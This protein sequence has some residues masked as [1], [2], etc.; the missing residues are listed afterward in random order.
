LYYTMLSKTKWFQLLYH[1]S[2]QIC[3]VIPC[4]FERQ[5]E[6]D[7][8]GHSRF[9]FSG[10]RNRADT[11][12]LLN[13]SWILSLCWNILRIFR[14]CRIYPASLHIK[15]TLLIN[16][17]YGKCILL[18]YAPKLWLLAMFAKLWI[19]FHDYS[20]ISYL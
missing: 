8:R 5:R 1:L 15:R 17:H 14:K 4:T 7:R 12:S 2:V 18:Y 3:F 16:A 9:R 10:I 11:N 13:P 6:N 20:A 19:S